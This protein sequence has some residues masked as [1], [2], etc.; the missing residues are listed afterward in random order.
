MKYNSYNCTRPCHADQNVIIR[1][2]RQ[3]VKGI[4]DVRL[5]NMNP[6]IILTIQGHVGISS[7]IVV[8]RKAI[9]R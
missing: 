7:T 4:N 6:N 1:N 3:Y 2:T 8:Y 9:H 5:Y